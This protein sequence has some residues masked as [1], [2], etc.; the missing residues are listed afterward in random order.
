MFSRL[1][2]M[3]SATI[4]EGQYRCLATVVNTLNEFFG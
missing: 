3:L 4:L 2:S 1:F